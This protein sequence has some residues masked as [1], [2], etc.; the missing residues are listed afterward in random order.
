M[1][2]HIGLTNNSDIGIH[3]SNGATSVFISVIGLSGS[4]LAKADNEKRLI[5]WLMEKDQSKVGIGTVGFSLSEMPWTKDKFDY[6]KTFLLNV[7]GSVK[8]KLGWDTLD[9]NP[10]EEI[11]FPIIDKFYEMVELF[12]SKDIDEEAIKEWLEASDNTEPMFNDFPLCE[13]HKILL[14]CFGC[15]ACND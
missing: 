14:T 9:Y 5:V 11:I 6:E 12:S 1:A 4:R 3:M 13:K 10:S 15:H 8:K 7:I 2:N